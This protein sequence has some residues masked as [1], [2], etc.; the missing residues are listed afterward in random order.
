MTS[1][2]CEFRQSTDFISRLQYREAQKMMSSMNRHRDSATS[3][4]RKLPKKCFDWLAN[5]LLAS[6]SIFDR[7]R[8]WIYHSTELRAFSAEQNDLRKDRLDIELHDTHGPWTMRT[9]FY[10]ISGTCVYRSKYT[11]GKTITTLNIETL[12]FLASKEPESLLPVKIAASQNPGQSSG[13]VKGITCIQAIWFCS[14]CIARMSNGMAISLLELNTFAHCVS[15]LFIYGFWWY[16][17]YDVNSHIFVQRKALDF[18]FLKHT[19]VEASEQPCINRHFA[20]VGF[21]T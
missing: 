4:G 2:G 6:F 8:M 18:L 5:I 3:Q 16:K 10:A 20:T 14:Q 12:N 15:A 13:I 1:K 9:A 21:F 17:P 7:V 19:A 11:T